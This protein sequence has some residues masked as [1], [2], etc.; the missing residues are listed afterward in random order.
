MLRHEAG[1]EACPAPDKDDAG[2]TAGIVISI[3]IVVIVIIVVVV[4]GCCK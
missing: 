3:V 2:I 1:M 4:L